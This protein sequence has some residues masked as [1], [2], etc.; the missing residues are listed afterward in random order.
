[1]NEKPVHIPLVASLFT[2]LF[3]I[4]LSF[5]VTSLASPYI[6]SDLGGDRSITF[7][8]LSFFGFGNVV[9][10]PLAKPLGAKFGEEKIFVYCVLAFALGSLLCAL[11]P[12]YFWFVAARFAAGMASGPFYPLLAHYFSCL[13]PSHKR[14][15]I[16]WVFVTMLVVVPVLG[17]C[18]G[19]TVAYLYNWRAVFFL[20]AAAGLPLSWIIKTY[21]KDAEIGLLRPGFDWIGWGF[22]AV[23]ICGI[24]FSLTMAQ[25]IDWYRSEAFN[26]ALILGIVCFG[27]Y[28]LRSFTHESPPLALWMFSKPVFALAILCL[29]VLFA[30]LYGMIILLAIWLTLDARFTPLWIAVLIGHMAIAGLFPRFIIEEKMGKIDPRIWIGLAT[31]LLAIS[32]FYTTTFDVLID[33]QRIALS[34][35][36]AGFGLALYLPPDFPDFGAVPQARSLG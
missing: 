21:L 17:A 25:Q 6:V 33:F 16:A 14:I 10:I 26:A 3:L 5:T 9:T 22:Y 18:W 13:V 15:I 11:A 28:L 23:G 12:T 30:V 7:Y 20:N 34:R 36:I 8:A 2:T 27:Y 31:A 24:A 4:V 1:M 19:G 29:A 32:C 35:V